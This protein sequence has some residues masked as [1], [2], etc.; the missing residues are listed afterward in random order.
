M[1][2][3][4]CDGR[5]DRAHR[6]VRSGAPRGRIAG[7]SAR[8]AQAPRP[9]AGI[10]DR[11]GPRPLAVGPLALSLAASRASR[12]TTTTAS[13]APTTTTPDNGI[14]LGSAKRRV[15]LARCNACDDATGGCDRRAGPG[16]FERA[17]PARTLPCHEDPSP[18]PVPAV[19]PAQAP[20]RSPA[21]AGD[22]T[23]LDHGPPRRRHPCPCQTGL[24]AL[25]RAPCPMVCMRLAE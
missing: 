21:T 5:P 13:A 1:S 6:P 22:D 24:P 25:S 17:P 7:S 18:S 4:R 23:D 2:P 15:S 19:L 20:G 14:N 16:T 10:A 9:P 3:W 12:T 8:C 11:P